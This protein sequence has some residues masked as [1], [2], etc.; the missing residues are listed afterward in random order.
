M[1]TDKH[2][3]EKAI[4]QHLADVAPL[5]A[6]RFGDYQDSSEVPHSDRSPTRRAY[7]RPRAVRVQPVEAKKLTG[8]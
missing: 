4:W 6:D 8:E 3:L 7:A 1:D 5:G 2:G